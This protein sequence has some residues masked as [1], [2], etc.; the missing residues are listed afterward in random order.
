MT[1]YMQKENKSLL[2]ENQEKAYLTNHR[3]RILLD[4]K[5]TYFDLKDPKCP[6]ILQENFV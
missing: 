2:L 4:V 3:D 6:K 5:G 1:K